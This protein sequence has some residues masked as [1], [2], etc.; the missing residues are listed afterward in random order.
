ME[1]L[2]VGA[3][4]GSVTATEQIA[5]MAILQVCQLRPVE[6]ARL[7]QH[8]RLLPEFAVP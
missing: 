4:H 5:S 3:A 1:T 6:S 2:C 8:M 7:R